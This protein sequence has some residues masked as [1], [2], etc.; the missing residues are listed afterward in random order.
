MTYGIVY[1]E[2]A[3]DDLLEVFDFTCCTSREAYACRAMFYYMENEAEIRLV[4]LRIL[5]RPL[6]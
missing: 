6:P 4:G 2:H 1:G 5:K 3:F